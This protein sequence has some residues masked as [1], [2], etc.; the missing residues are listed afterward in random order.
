MYSTAANVLLVAGRKPPNGYVLNSDI[1]P[2]HLLF[3][4]LNGTV[5]NLPN[6]A[7]SACVDVDHDLRRASIAT[8][9]EWAFPET[10]RSCADLLG[11]G[12]RRCSLCKPNVLLSFGDIAQQTKNIMSG[13]KFHPVVAVVFETRDFGRCVARAPYIDMGGKGIDGGDSII[14]VPHVVIVSMKL[15]HVGPH[16]LVK[17]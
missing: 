13:G 11:S 3:K 8:V 12:D 14:G 16:D 15:R 10:N 9:T 5:Y 1:Q 7:H 4:K 6:V 2:S 17:N